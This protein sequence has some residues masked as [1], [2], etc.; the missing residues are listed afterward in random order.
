M[1]Y[2]N[3]DFRKEHRMANSNRKVKKAE[4]EKQEQTEREVI[5]VCFVA[6]SLFL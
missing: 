2:N 1:V 3:G 4:L 6:L 5:G